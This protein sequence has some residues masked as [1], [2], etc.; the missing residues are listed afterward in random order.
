MKSALLS[1]AFLFL[2]STAKSDEESARLKELDAFWDTISKAV[3]TGDFASYQQTCHPEAI[4][5]S[6]SK[7]TAYPLA[8]ALRRWKTE[9]DNT[10]LN[11]RTST[12]SFRFQKRYGSATSAHESGMLFYSFQDQNKE[13]SKT[14]IHF[15]ALLTKKNGHWLL[16]MENQKS[17]GT[18]EE[19]EALAKKNS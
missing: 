10:R 18:Q 11:K 17:T 2:A 12:V 15:E 1:F 6:G 4:L 14:Y 3:K 7:K 13:L 5:V 19:W 9:F 8:Q 16:I